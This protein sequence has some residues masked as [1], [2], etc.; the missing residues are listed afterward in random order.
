M[1]SAAKILWAAYTFQLTWCHGP[2]KDFKLAK[3]EGLKLYQVWS[4]HLNL[5][6]FFLSFPFPLQGAST[7][8]AA[9]VQLIR[10]LL[11]KNAGWLPL[12]ENV[13]L[14]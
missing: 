13:T 2:N 11:Q 7:A 1:K 10:S 5:P 9:E 6:L 3:T 8:N 12:E 14:R 4:E